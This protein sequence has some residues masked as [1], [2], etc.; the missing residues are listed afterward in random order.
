MMSTLTILS[1]MPFSYQ[2]HFLS[3]L[4]VLKSGFLNTKDFK[5]VKELAE[6]MTRL[7]NDKNAYNAFFKDLYLNKPAKIL[8]LPVNINRL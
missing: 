7:G 4:K 2:I 3:I 8:N 5:T 6:H 1:Q